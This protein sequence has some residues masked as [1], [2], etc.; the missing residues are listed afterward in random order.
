MPQHPTR[1]P[2]RGPRLPVVVR[3]LAPVLL[4]FLAL[5]YVLVPQLPGLDRTLRVLSGISPLVGLAAVAAQAGSLAAYTQ[6]ARGLVEPPARPRFA[7]MLRPQLVTVGMSHVLPGGG[8]AAT[9]FGFRV[10]RRTGLTPAEAG[11]VLG[12]EAAVSWMVLIAVLWTALLVSIPF[13]DG[14]APYI[15][16]AAAGAAV[17]GGVVIAV[18]GAFRASRR[19]AGLVRGTARLL[20]ADDP[21]AAVRMVRATARRFR[22][23]TAD[24][25]RA[26][27]AV[28]WGVTQVALDALSL[29]L[30]LA[31][32]GVRVPPDALVV[33]YGLANVSAAVPLTPGGVAVFEAVLVSAMTAF[34]TPATASVVGV[35]A[36]RLVQFWLPIPI[37]LALYVSA[38]LGGGDGAAVRR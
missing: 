4:A 12:A 25:R 28:G 35:L 36:Y 37:G 18:L 22:D 15:G 32:L 8:V 26:A 27:R 17:I 13:R 5:H 6:L 31:A 10:L 30:F 20:R 7:A 19:V 29:W 23:L 21:E 34:G 9:P 38:D 33:S 14:N 2:F 24:R 1:T 11:L 16:L 3:R